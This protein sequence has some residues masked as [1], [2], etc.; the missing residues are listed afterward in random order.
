MLDA[1]GANT[2]AAAAVLAAAKHVDLSGAMAVVLGATGP[3]GSR[4]VRLLATGGAKRARRF[5][6]GAGT[7]TE[8]VCQTVRTAVPS[9]EVTPVATG[10][11]DE[12]RAVLMGAVDPDRCRHCWRTTRFNRPA[13]QLSRLGRGDRPERRPAG[14]PRRR[15]ANRQGR[16]SVTAP[17]LRRTRRRRRENENPQGSHPSALHGE[18]SNPRRRG[19][20]CHRAAIR[21][22][23]NELTLGRFAQASRRLALAR[24]RQPS[25]RAAFRRD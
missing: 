8:S 1:N 10:S 18:R 15:Q 9:A 6:C 20:V 16:R 2:T 21:R 22:V 3:V 19:S 23:L 4:A 11:A 12:T 25:R 17:L 7:G 5:T 13:A 14:R 24:R